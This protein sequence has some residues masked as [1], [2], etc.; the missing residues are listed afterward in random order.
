MRRSSLVLATLLVAGVAGVGQAQLS[1]PQPPTIFEATP[2]AG[3]ILFGD[4]LSG[5]LGTSV[6]NA[7]ATIIGAQLGMKIAPNVSIIGNV[8]TASSDIQAGIPILG[9]V[10]I[11]QST[12]QMFDAGL[13]LELPFTSISGLTFSPILQ[14]GAG[15][16]RYAITQSFIT[17]NSTNFAANVAAGADI[18]VGRGV[19][20]RF[21]AKDYIGNFDMQQATFIDAQTNTTNSFAFSAGLR[22][23]F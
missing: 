16:M 13:Q 4:Y 1:S 3:V 20:V 9:G 8:A 19:G 17:T 2:Y 21:M 10:S 12:V 23:S 11:A 18:S 5:P 7:P 22:F 15:A 14:A 6:T